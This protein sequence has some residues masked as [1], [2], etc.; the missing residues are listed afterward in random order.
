[1]L[2]EPT[3]VTCVLEKEDVDKIENIA[4][5]TGANKSVLIRMWITEKL[6]QL[7]PVDLNKF[8]GGE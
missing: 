4:K 5:E 6:R 2:K 1:M 8:R 3:N 7:N